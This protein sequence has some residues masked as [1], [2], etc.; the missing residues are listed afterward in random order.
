MIFRSNLDRRQA[1]TLMLA[2]AGASV[3]PVVSFAEEKLDEADPTAAGLQYTHDAESAGKTD[4][5]AMCALYTGAEGEEL[6][7]CNIFPGKLVTAKGWC[8]AFA[9]KP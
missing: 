3:V 6:G 5:C 1:L 7:G 4:T 2:G 8:S 9:A